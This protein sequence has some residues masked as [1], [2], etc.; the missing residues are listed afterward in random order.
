MRGAAV[1]SCLETGVCCVVGWLWRRQSAALLGSSWLAN[2]QHSERGGRA[3]NHSCRSH[4][5][6]HWYAAD[7]MHFNVKPRTPYYPV[8]WIILLLQDLALCMFRYMCMDVSHQ[9][10]WCKRRPSDVTRVYV[11]SSVWSV[12]RHYVQRPRLVQRWRLQLQRR[13][14]RLQLRDSVRRRLR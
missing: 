5:H 12:W 7:V 6:R 13:L 2:F 11:Y 1:I 10:C 8:P 9:L 4:H 3:G 14:L